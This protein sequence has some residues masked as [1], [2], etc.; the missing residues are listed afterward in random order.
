MFNLVVKGLEG[1]GVATNART[2][3]RP[4]LH[5]SAAN[6][7]NNALPADVTPEIMAGTSEHF[8]RVLHYRK[9]ADSSGFS[10]GHIQAY[11]EAR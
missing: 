2:N 5:P 11:A 4:P 8:A 9:L 6:S 1:D 3:G 7:V 10:S